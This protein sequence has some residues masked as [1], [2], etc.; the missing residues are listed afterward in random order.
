MN[1]GYLEMFL[2]F[3]QEMV[4]NARELHNAG[5]VLKQHM[6]QRDQEQTKRNT[7]RSA[8]LAERAQRDWT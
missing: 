3:R 1:D 7:E 2:F 8:R 5:L 4:R 6:E